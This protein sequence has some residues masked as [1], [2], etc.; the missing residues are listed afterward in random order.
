MLENIRGI[1]G[2]Y[3]EW[4]RSVTSMASHDPLWT[5]TY[6]SIKTYADRAR[7]EKGWSIDADWFLV[8]NDGTEY[9]LPD[10]EVMDDLETQLD[11]HRAD[12]WTDKLN[13]AK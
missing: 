3:K 5:K 13:L 12:F 9:L 6:Q 11:Q 10:L 2:R 4:P 1:E 8:M 7:I